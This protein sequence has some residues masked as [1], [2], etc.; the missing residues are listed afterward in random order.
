MP[1]ACLQPL[2]PP[3]MTVSILSTAAVVTHPSSFFYLLWPLTHFSFKT[4]SA[5][6]R[7]ER[8]SALS[9]MLPTAD[10]L[11]RRAHAARD[12]SGTDRSHQ[13]RSRSNRATTAPGAGVGLA[14]EAESGGGAAHTI[15]TNDKGV[16]V[17][18]V[19]VGGREVRARFVDIS[20][21]RER[22]WLNRRMLTFWESS[23]A[24][25][26]SGWHFL[27]KSDRSSPQCV[28][29]LSRPQG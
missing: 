13:P 3:Y 9:S 19:N 24:C 2:A 10:R 8:L 1:R 5:L 22:K 20:Y 11:H 15:D 27:P 23:C 18:K 29:R 21:E 6:R 16:S 25:I 28:S 7:D 12:A 17:L 4:A 14:M 26:R